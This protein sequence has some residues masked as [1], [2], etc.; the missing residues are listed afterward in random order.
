MDFRRFLD[1]I[2]HRRDYEHQIAH[3]EHLPARPAQFAELA[4][5]LPE[6]LRAVL[7]RD[8]ITRLY[9]HQVSAIEAI[10]GGQNVVIVA[11]TAGGKTLCY[12][13]PVLE[14]LLADPHAKAVYLFPT[15]ALAQDQLRGLGRLKEADPSLPIEAGTYDG[16]TP[17]NQRRKLRDEGNIILTNPDM[18]H[19]GILPNHARWSDFFAQLKYVVID[20]VH[21]Y[22]GIL[23]SNVANVVRRLRRV[24]RHYGADPQFIGC[25]ATIGNPDELAARLIGAPVTLIG[26]DGSPRG[27][28]RFLLW[29]PPFLDEAKMERRS[30]N[31]EAQR[32]MVELIKSG[33]QTITFVRARV[34]AEL[35]YRYV[36]DELAKHSHRLAD[37]IRAYR[38]GYLPEE[39][40]EIERRLFSGDLMGVTTTNALE[41]GIDIGSL[42]ACI[43]VGYPGSIAS[44]WQQ[45][46]RAGRRDE[47]ALVI[48]IGQ[49]TP[50][51]QYLME[52]TDYFFGRPTERAVIDPE[53]PHVLAGHLR[54][55]CAEL[56]VD[57]RDCELFGEYAPAVMELL[58]EAGQAYERRG[59][60]YWKGPAYP[61]G[62]VNLRNIDQHNYLIQD[63]TNENQVIGMMD[64]LSA[65]TLLHG[66]AIYLHV[67]ETYFVDKL[68]LKEKIAYV[69]KGDFDYYTQAVD[70]SD[71]RVEE[72]EL[73]VPWRVSEACFGPV[74][75]TTT[76]Y[77]FRKM[78]LASR[79]SIGF[80]NLDLPPRELNTDALWLLPPR[81]VLER[82]RAY[83]RVPEDGLLGIANA[84]VGV[85]PLW[86]MCDPADVGS[87]VDSANVGSPAIFL[88]D[89]YPG[90]L[91][92]AQKAHTLVEEI[93]ESALFL[94]Q[95]CECEE[96]CPSCV[97]SP[98][99]PFGPQ[100]GD[101]DTRGKI[102]DREAALCL[103][104]DLL[105]KEPYVPKAP[106]PARAE[107]LMAQWQ[108]SMAARAAASPADELPAERPPVKRLPETVERKIRRRIQSLKR[109]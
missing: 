81:Q 69:R 38:G 14:T 8:G 42:D 82:V 16:D 53:N 52:K 67:G 29:N 6:A 36:Q 59:R 100:S 9:T 2:Q 78:K 58:E 87:V 92:F 13:L 46:G 108:R 49:N 102:P 17:A 23:G 4:P 30:P 7:E 54:C 41:L 62:D 56:P 5:A 63:T 103:L 74:T 61:A 88:Y 26:N 44:T 73:S 15:K 107:R 96:G 101:S 94:I 20:E 10:R 99:P 95:E 45:A 64:E 21:Y 48:L 60:W 97:G 34:T 86:V 27:P 11:G 22:R 65:F 106:D 93:L 28:K 98:L 35:L 90:G 18:L 19:S 75:V 80:G 76:V 89:R 1:E 37:C 77:M 43:L 55:A 68:D 70:R 85:L 3:I 31:T 40:R 79:D 71:I 32:L 72:T 91:G 39:R 33:V 66:Q 50:I 47:E 105:Q 51:D 83:Q 12:N 104:H 84:A 109:Q 24:C 25:S 57:A